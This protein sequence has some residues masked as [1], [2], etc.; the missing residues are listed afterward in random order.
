MWATEKGYQAMAEKIKYLST[1]E[2]V[3]NAKEIEEARSHGDLRENAEFK[4]AL[5]RRDRLQS[6]L[7]FLSEQYN[8]A[9]ILR[10]EDVKTESVGI[11]VVV[12]CASSDGQNKAYTILG[13]FEADVEKNIISFQSK[14]AQDLLG[15]QK[16]DKITLRSEELTITDLRN[17][18][19]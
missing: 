11:G 1:V 12:H 9:R 3:D 6:E 15:K 18:F 19:D 17:Y 4:A 7:A 16:G 2:T 10:K 8:Q 14:M 13:P 5:E